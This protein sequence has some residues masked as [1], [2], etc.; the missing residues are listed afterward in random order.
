M[1]VS[2]KLGCNGGLISVDDCVVVATPNL[3]AVGVAR[4]DMPDNMDL[5]GTELGRLEFIDQP[6]KFGCWICAV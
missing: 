4:W 5:F 6:L 2:E 3:E 1:S